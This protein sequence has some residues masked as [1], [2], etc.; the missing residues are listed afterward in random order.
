MNP[1]MLVSQPLR[2]EN[3]R[4]G[5]KQVGIQEAEARVSTSTRREHP[6]GMKT[7]C[8]SFRISIGLNLYA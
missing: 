7:L 6:C 2:V 1:E 4:V 3:T 8:T 5:V